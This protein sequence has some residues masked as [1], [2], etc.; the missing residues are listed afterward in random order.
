[1][2][3]T[4]ERG[5]PA[6]HRSKLLQK[7]SE[8][9][10]GRR[11]R[12]WVYAECKQDCSYPLRWE[13]RCG[14]HRG[15]GRSQEA[16]APSAELLKWWESGSTLKSLCL[17]WEGSKTI[18]DLEKHLVKPH[19]WNFIPCSELLILFLG[20]HRSVSRAGPGDG[21]WAGKYDGEREGKVGLGQTGCWETQ[22][23]TCIKMILK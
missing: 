19:V 21:P 14:S 2:T 4:G 12:N 7:C 11:W 9:L 8:I 6:A 20:V 5:C 17:S 23:A 18:K 13:N 22:R 10:C 3:Q 1:M 15:R 16:R